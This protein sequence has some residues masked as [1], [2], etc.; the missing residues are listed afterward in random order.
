MIEI[1]LIV[2][3]KSESPL[4]MPFFGWSLK[5]CSSGQNLKKT[6]KF[7]KLANF[8]SFF[9]VKFFATPEN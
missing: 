3:F 5:N 9:N 7:K 1:F 6:S 4:G 8:G 2:I